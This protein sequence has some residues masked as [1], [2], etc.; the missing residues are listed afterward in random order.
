MGL[1]TATEMADAVDNGEITL[2]RSISWHLTSNHYPPVP[3]TMVE[4]CIKAIDADNLD[5]PNREIT[6]PDGVLYRDRSTAPAW[7]I[8]ENFHLSPWLSANV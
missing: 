7:A 5:D 4:A 1:N 6:L 3:V 2:G 8:I